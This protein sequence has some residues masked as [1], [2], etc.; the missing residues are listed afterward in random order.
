MINKNQRGYDCL[1]PKAYSLKGEER[2]IQKK[3]IFI[4]FSVYFRY[5][6]SKLFNYS[7]PWMKIS[8]MLKTIKRL[9]LP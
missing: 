4:V 5:R 7:C 3:K 1:R 6:I 2:G 8:L 9:Q